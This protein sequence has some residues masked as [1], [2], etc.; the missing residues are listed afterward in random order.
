MKC[1]SIW[2]PFASLIVSG[3]KTFE[4]RSWAAPA[5]LIGQ[6]IGIAATKNINA[7]QRQFFEDEDFRAAYNSTNQPALS[8]LP[9]GVLLGTV[10][11]DSVELMTEEMME[12]VSDEEKLYGWW[13]EGN[14]GWRLT[15]PVPLTHPCII[16]GQQ[17]LYD[18]RGEL[19]V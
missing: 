18:W 3:C 10:I 5:S 11:L 13:N 1:I 7:A 14:Y 8:D 12:D 2:Q 6:R 15:D 16:R 19:P 9:M 17:G 4:T